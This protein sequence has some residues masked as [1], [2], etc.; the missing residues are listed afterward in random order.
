MAK[1][2]CVYNAIGGLL[3]NKGVLYSENQPLTTCMHALIVQCSIKNGLSPNVISPAIVE[4]EYPCHQ[5]TIG[6]TPIYSIT[7]TEIDD[8]Y[9]YVHVHCPWRSRV[10]L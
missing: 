4:P 3:V 2:L 8:A 10:D 1:L 7:Y 9:M 5:Y 6:Y